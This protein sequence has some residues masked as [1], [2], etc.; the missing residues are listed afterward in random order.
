MQQQIKILN[1]MRKEL[2]M[3]RSKNIKLI[4]IFLVACACL[5][6]FSNSVNA[7]QN[8]R[9]IVHYCEFALSDI[10]VNKWKFQD[11]TNPSYTDENDVFRNW[12]NSIQKGI[13]LVIDNANRVFGESSN[14]QYIRKTPEITWFNEFNSGD[15]TKSNITIVNV[16]GSLPSRTGDKWLYVRCYYQTSSN[17]DGRITPQDSGIEIRPY[18]TND[19]NLSW[20]VIPTTCT[21]CPITMIP[22]YSIYGSKLIYGYG[23]NQTWRN[24]RVSLSEEGFFAGTSPYE[25]FR[26]G[27]NL[28]YWPTAIFE[29]GTFLV[30]DEGY[31]P[32]PNQTNGMIFYINNSNETLNNISNFLVPRYINTTIRDLNEPTNWPAADGRIRIIQGHEYNMTT[33]FN[34]T[35]RVPMK[36]QIRNF[37]ECGAMDGGIGMGDVDIKICSASSVSSTEETLAPSQAKSVNYTFTTPYPNITLKMYDTLKFKNKNAPQSTNNDWAY[38]WPT[39]GGEEYGYLGFFEIVA[40]IELIKNETTGEHHPVFKITPGLKVIDYGFNQNVFQED[41]EIVFKIWNSTMRV[42]ANLVYEENISLAQAEY[43]RGVRVPE[44]LRV[45]VDKSWMSSLRENYYVRLYLKAMGPRALARGFSGKTVAATQ[46]NPYFK[47]GEIAFK[48]KDMLVFSEDGKNDTDMITIFNP[49]FGEIDINLSVDSWTDTEN[50]TINWAEYTEGVR[51]ES[52]FGKYASKTIHLAPLEWKDVEVVVNA[53]HY[54]WPDREV[55]QN[56]KVNMSAKIN[57]G[58]ENKTTTLS[59]LLNVTNSSPLYY[60]L[61]TYNIFP[62]EITL[63]SL[64][65][66]KNEKIDAYWFERGSWRKLQILQSSGAGSSSVNYNVNVK[67]LNT[68]DSAHE[69]VLN[70]TTKTFSPT[71]TNIRKN[72]DISYDF[73]M[74]TYAVV[75]TLDVGDSITGEVDSAGGDG[76]GVDNL[77]RWPINIKACSY[78][79]VANEIYWHSGGVSHLD[80]DCTCDVCAA[81]K[82]PEYVCSNGKCVNEMNVEECRG[83]SSY[84]N[85]NNEAVHT[86][87][88]C[89]WNCTGPFC[90][91]ADVNSGV[92]L[93]CGEIF[94]RCSGYNNQITCEDDPCDKNN[95]HCCGRSD[96]RPGARCDLS[97]DLFNC[98]GASS[99]NC[100]WDTTDNRCKFKINGC[101]YTPV[102]LTTCEESNVRFAVFNLTGIPTATCE[103]FQFEQRCPR[104]VE[105][106]FFDVFGLISVVALMILAYCIVLIRRK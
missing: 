33:Y 11:S 104:Q 39:I 42:A 81:Q 6:I 7:D 29:V 3:C 20:G 50:F 9:I 103:N 62:D 87:F 92:C 5:F 16:N 68:T 63:S 77:G 96:L 56:L 41:Y 78:N 75:L 79:E 69:V 24:N 90:P 45:V 4:S 82:G 30:R 73:S 91:P 52:G 34:N 27:K 44:N 70:E 89:G 71:S 49:S 85:C 101:T 106:P 1:K 48:G 83:Q 37:Y 95:K 15:G 23:R 74:G 38:E 13:F 61:D 21:N 84:A 99:Y 98:R 105:L 46:T 58:A 102:P 93:A 28:K 8:D 12:D 31:T 10:D 18:A 67:L 66:V 76:E 25:I 35:F 47:P 51:S 59:Y 100:V 2:K 55:Y 54:P 64:A 72:I 17:A 36:I 97:S 40:E 65:D 43:H 57:Y 19:F 60:D 80:V 32:L 22:H 88:I 94:D 86:G 14:Y 26:I 53:S